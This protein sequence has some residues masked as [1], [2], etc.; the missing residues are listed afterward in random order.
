MVLNPARAWIRQLA[1][2]TLLLLVW[3]AAGQAGLL[4]P[5]YVP[6]PSR[7]AGALSELFAS[8]RT[9][10]QLSRRRSPD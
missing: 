9:W 1:A 5:L 8:G 4:N 10:R 3:E 6:S 2:L 7:I